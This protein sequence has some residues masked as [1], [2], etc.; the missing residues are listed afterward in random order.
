MPAAAQEEGAGQVLEW[1]AGRRGQAQFL[2]NLM[3]GLAAPK[4]AAGTGREIQIVQGRGL[5]VDPGGL[6]RPGQ[7]ARL[8]VEM[9]TGEV[10]QGRVV[11]FPAGPAGRER[12]RL[13]IERGVPCPGPS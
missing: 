12:E 9:C 11:R 5:V 6:R 3:E 1:P 13:V 7:A 10:S 8:E 4:I 2:G